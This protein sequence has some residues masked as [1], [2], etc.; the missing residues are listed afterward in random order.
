V[1]Y[2]KIVDLDDDRHV[3]IN[4]AGTKFIKMKSMLTDFVMIMGRMQR[5]N[6]T[7]NAARAMKRICFLI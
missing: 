5:I 2:F 6:S 4:I 3:M 1:T 7:T